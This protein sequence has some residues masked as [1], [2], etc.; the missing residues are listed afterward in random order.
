M[1]KSKS[2]KREVYSNHISNL[3]Y[4]KYNKLTLYTSTKKEKNIVNPELAEGR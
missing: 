2:S 3:E 4:Q 1:G